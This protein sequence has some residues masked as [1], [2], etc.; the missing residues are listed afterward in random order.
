MSGGGGVLLQEPYAGWLLSGVGWTLLVTAVSWTVA[1]LV[2]LPVGAAHAGGARPVRLLARVYVELFRNVPPLVQLFLWFFVVPEV[3]PDAARPVDQARHAAARVHHRLAR[4]RP[5]R[6]ARVAEQVRA[7]LEAVGARLL[8]AALAT[9][10][11]PAQ[12]YRLVLL[13]VALRTLLAPLT[14][15]L[16][17]TVKMSSVALTVGVTELT[18]QSRQVADTTFQGFQAYGA[19]TALYLLIGLALTGLVRLLERRLAPAVAA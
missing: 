4:H 2:G 7:G 15:E 16:L 5:V 13:P 10:L 11:R 6:G 17:I 19:A 1:L 8:P 18:A 9:G 3:L 12:A 14:S